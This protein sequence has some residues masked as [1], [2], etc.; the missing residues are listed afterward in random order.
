[1][2]LEFDS[3]S[4]SVGRVVPENVS[5]I[6]KQVLN[7]LA[8]LMRPTDC[9]KL[10]I[11]GAVIATDTV[12][13]VDFLSR[14]KRSPEKFL[15]NEMMQ[16]PFSTSRALLNIDVTGFVR[17]VRQ[18]LLSFWSNHLNGRRSGIVRPSIALP[19][20]STKDTYWRSAEPILSITAV[21][22]AMRAERKRGVSQ[23]GYS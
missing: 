16:G 4:F 2:G 8:F 7:R 17:R 19:M 13:M 6:G 18:A 21:N 12:F 22:S 23:N 1:M 11:L 14:P 5:R 20:G 3:E 10:Q 9:D 15:H